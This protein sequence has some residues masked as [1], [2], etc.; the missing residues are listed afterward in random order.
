ML[1]SLLLNNV[2]VKITSVHIRLRSKLTSN[3]T[4]NL[5]EKSFSTKDWVLLNPI[6][7]LWMMLKDLF[8]RYQDHMKVKKPLILQEMT[9]FYEMCL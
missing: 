9:I 1:E 4:K 2:K 7:V 6:L 8:K 5:T 3:K